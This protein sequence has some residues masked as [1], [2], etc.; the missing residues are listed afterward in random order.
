[1]RLALIFAFLAPAFACSAVDSD[2]IT[3]QDLA[4]AS[5]AFAS[6]DPGL[7]L[8]PAPLP[9][10]ERV[11]HADELVRLA[12]RNGIAI[13]G[14]IAEVCFARATEPLTAQKLLPILRSALNIDGAQI[15]IL[16][17]N[18]VGVPRGTIEFTRAGLTPNGLWHGRAHFDEN[19]TIP[20]WV[21]VRVT[22]EQTWVEA[23]A[24]LEPGKPI[25]TAQLKLVT[26]A[27]TFFGPSPINSLHQ[28]DGH[29]ALRTVRPGEPIFPNML[30]A[31]REVERGDTVSVNV[32]SG[33]AHLSFDAVSESAG[34]DGDLIL[35][36]NP[37]NGRLFQ[38][39]VV[40]KDKVSINK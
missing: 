2:R 30:V 32:S 7:I 8:S 35:L 38:A 33:A 9:P 11:F 15:E 23:A 12:R 14:P 37:D 19:R 18:R 29:A 16:D 31:A 25:D 6:L 13:S 28:A 39:R 5:P 17:F 22:T 40:A 21:R 10:V 4:A 36:K 20:I 27:R 1:M 3:A 34:R 26:G 24:Q